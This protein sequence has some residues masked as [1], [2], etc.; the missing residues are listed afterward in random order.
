MAY[1]GDAPRP[2][3]QPLSR[4]TT[5]VGH[6]C[7]VHGETE[8]PATKSQMEKRHTETNQRK[9]DG[10]LDPRAVKKKTFVMFFYYYCKI[11]NLNKLLEQQ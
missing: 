11:N 3:Q 1:D 10:Q 2:A 5:H 4:Q 7:V 9:S 6:V 8:D